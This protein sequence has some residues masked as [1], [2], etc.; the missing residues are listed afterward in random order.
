MVGYWSCMSVCEQSTTNGDGNM[1]TCVHVGKGFEGEPW[2]CHRVAPVSGSPIKN[3]FVISDRPGLHTTDV[4]VNGGPINRIPP[5]RPII[6]GR[7]EVELSVLKPRIR[8]GRISTGPTGGEDRILELVVLSGDERFHDH[9]PFFPPVS[10]RWELGGV[11][12]GRGDLVREV[13]S[14]GPRTVVNDWGDAD[15]TL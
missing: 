3:E 7:P 11:S 12:G 10:A 2:V 5:N 13:L 15:L 1:D 4:A 14:S 8:G 6:E 9:E